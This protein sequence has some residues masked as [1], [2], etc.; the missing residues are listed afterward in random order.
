MT[1]PETNR[2]Q[3]DPSGLYHTFARHRRETETAISK[4]FQDKE[5]GPNPLANPENHGDDAFGKDGKAHRTNA[6]QESGCTG[7]GAN[8]RHRGRSRRPRPGLAGGTR[9]R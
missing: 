6:I 9:A 1:T 4:M 7:I 3:P 5:G 8:R 2:R